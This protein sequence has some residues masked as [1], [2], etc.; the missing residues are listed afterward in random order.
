MR[1]NNCCG[2][3]K[4]S[5]YSKEIKDFICINDSSENY[6]CE[7]EFRSHCEEHEYKEF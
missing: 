1:E 7:T 5:Q 4:Y 2:N 6:G 3:C